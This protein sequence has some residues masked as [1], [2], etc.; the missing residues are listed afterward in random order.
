MDS[1]PKNKADRTADQPAGE[2]KRRGMVNCPA[3]ARNA[4]NGPESGKNGQAM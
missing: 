4:R 1:G 2:A 3:K